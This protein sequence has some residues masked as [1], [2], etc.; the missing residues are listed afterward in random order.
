MYFPLDDSY[1]CGN[2]VVVSHNLFHR[3]R[4]SETKQKSNKTH[5][6]YTV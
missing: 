5:L 4:R 2:S 6:D 1:R 3:L